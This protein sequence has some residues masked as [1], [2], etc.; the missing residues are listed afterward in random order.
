MLRELVRKIDIPAPQVLIE[1][2]IV[3]ATRQTAWEL[4]VQWGGLYKTSLIRSTD[5]WLTPKAVSTLGSA[6][7]INT[8]LLPSP[9]IGVNLPT[10][11]SGTDESVGLNLGV[12]MQK[13]GSN[14]LAVQL[15]SLQKDG[16]LRILSSPS[17]TTLDNQ[18]ASIESGKEV[19]FQTVENG[20]VNV[21]FKKAVLSLK[22]T[23]HVIDE[24][25]LKLAILTHKDELDFSNDV[26][27][28]PTIIT[29]NAETNVVLFDGETT[30]IGGLS[31]E[32]LSDSEAGVP[33]LKDI[34]LIGYLFKRKG[35]SNDLEEILIFITPHIL[36]PK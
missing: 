21:E 25:T 28:N 4:G 29:K 8:Q 20:E 24:K 13:A 11:G 12:I 2:H 6:T 33:G 18:S 27:G 17:I 10:T 22:V 36:K 19:P 32:S 9:G 35:N 1:A 31:K 26:K 34:P 23:P 3:E 14:I 30:V 7:D 16:R 15:S 5:T